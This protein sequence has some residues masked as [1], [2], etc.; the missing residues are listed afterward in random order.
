M[1]H[2]FFPTSRDFMIFT[3]RL[4]P[5]PEHF[6]NS[7]FFLVQCVCIFVMVVSIFICLQMGFFFCLCSMKV[8]RRIFALEQIDILC[9]LTRNRVWSFLFGNWT[10]KL[11][12]LSSG[13]VGWDFFADPTRFCPSLKAS[14][15]CRWMLR[16]TPSRTVG[17]G[18]GGE[19]SSSGSDGYAGG[20]W[21]SACHHQGRG[22]AHCESLHYVLPGFS[23]GVE[24]CQRSA[25]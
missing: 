19:A 15:L 11:W 3:G 21:V 8:E 9:I 10:R 2:I 25:S 14:E 4:L 16:G 12:V 13:A 1:S 23:D 20:Q 5:M 22:S 6:S 18:E 17:N 7:I 24:V